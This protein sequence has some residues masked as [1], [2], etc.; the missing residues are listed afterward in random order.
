MHSGATRKAGLPTIGPELLEKVGDKMRTIRCEG[1]GPIVVRGEILKEIYFIARGRLE[2]RY[3]VPR[4]GPQ[5]LTLSAGDFFGERAVLEDD[6]SDAAVRPLEPGA[7]LAAVP[8][9]A[10]KAVLA[11]EPDLREAFV[12]CVAARRALLR[13]MALSRD[14]NGY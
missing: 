14:P 1:L 2:A 6:A 9:E 7:V 8:L 5:V 13:A 11:A 12:E 10:F 4:L 3:K